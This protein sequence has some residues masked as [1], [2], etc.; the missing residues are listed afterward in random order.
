M[1]TI[2]R[3]FG[4]LRTVSR[5]RREVRRNCFRAGIYV[6]GLTHDMSKFSPTEFFQGVRF[7]D[8]THSP[9]E[10]ERRMHGY[11][12][13]WM[14]HKGRNRHHWEY[15]TDY[16]VKEGR[17]LPVPMP[18][19]YLAETICDRIAASKIYKGAAYEDSCPLD[20]LQNGKMRDNMHP[21]TLEEIT[22]F[23]T[24]LK[25]RGEEAMFASLRAWLRE[26]T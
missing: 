6:Q 12:V 24:L 17:Y 25:D 8:G 13:A 26:E 11:S 5:H 15:W 14:H 18:R 1:T 21:Q 9:T 7:F 3:F 16:S 22:R 19:R 2:S 20:Y 4:H 10:D 23:L